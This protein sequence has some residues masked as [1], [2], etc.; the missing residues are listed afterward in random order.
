MPDQGGKRVAVVAGVRTP[1]AKMGTVFKDT[2][3][4]ELGRLTVAETLAQAD[5]DP[6]VVDEVVIGNTGNPAEAMNIARVIALDAGIPESTPANTVHRNCASG[7]QALTDAVTRIRAGEARCIVAGGAESMSNIPLFFSKDMAEIL[8][9]VM[10]SKSLPDKL[11]TLSHV[12]P[13]MLK[14]VVGLME[15]LTDPFC[16]LNMGQTAEV[17]AR[18]FQISRIEQ[19]TLALLS[20]KRA[21]AAQEAGRRDPELTPVFV[22]PAYS[23]I[24]EN[25]VG[26][27]PS[28]TLEALAKLR[29]VF[30]R[31]N[32]TVT[33]G[34]SCGV[35]DGACALLLM[36]EEM[37]KSQGYE[38][39]G[40][41]RSFAYAGLDP[42][43]MGLGPAFAS[44]LALDKAGMRLDQMDLIELN[45]A[46]AAQVI[47]CER[48][49]ASEEFC[50]KHLNRG[51]VGDI[52]REKLNVNGGAIAVG[53]PVGATGA[54]LVLTLLLELKRRNLNTGLATLCIGGGQGGAVVVERN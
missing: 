8:G 1:F 28:Q 44:P 37:A 47:A 30:D 13:E 9:R 33:A 32:G 39:L 23:E 29:P 17:L 35:T 7:L 54:R 36:S 43:R 53:H 25:D 41:I 11:E 38:P 27:R 50:R 20:H 3:A 15:G 40:F 24:V 14:P 2:S 51:K 16:G 12:R 52:D 49:L 26:P 22:A 19:D 48:A 34:N 5:I 4:Y 21:I 18:D 46:F 42:R 45:E 6:A 31:E 10:T